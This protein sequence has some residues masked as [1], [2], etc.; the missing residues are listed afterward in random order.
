[1]QKNT[2]IGQCGFLHTVS[3][4]A[5]SDL[6]VHLPAV[7]LSGVFFGLLRTDQAFHE[8]AVRKPFRGKMKP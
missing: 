1:M 3:N 7:F 2:E 8:K 4:P 6:P 5:E